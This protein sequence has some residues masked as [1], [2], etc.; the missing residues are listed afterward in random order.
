MNKVLKYIFLICLSTSAW[1]DNHWEKKKS[2]FEQHTQEFYQRRTNKLKSKSKHIQNKQKSD[3]EK[4]QLKWT[5]LE[6]RLQT[7]NR[8]QAQQ[9]LNLFINPKKYNK[10]DVKRKFI[11][12]KNKNKKLKEKYQIPL[13]EQLFL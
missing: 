11:D 5:F 3:L 1:A 9:L 6:N 4:S 10:K 7:D 8:G 13:E 2:N 12:T